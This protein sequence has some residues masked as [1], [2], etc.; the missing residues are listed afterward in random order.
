[1]RILKFPSLTA[2]IIVVFLD[3]STAVASMPTVKISGSYQ[4]TAA[5]FRG[6]VTYEVT[7]FPDDE[8]LFHLPPNWYI[9]NDD[10]N[11]YELQIDGDKHKTIQR[12]DLLTLKRSNHENIYLPQGIHVNS[13]T[14]NKSPT[15]FKIIENLRLSPLKYNKKTLL[16]VSIGRSSIKEAVRIRINFQTR[17]NHLP[18]GFQNL[19]WDFIPRL[20]GFYEGKW[21]RK[22]NIS[23]SFRQRAQVDMLDE[24][25]KKVRTIQSEYESP[26]PYLLL[27]NWNV[28]MDQLKLSYDSYFRDSEADLLNRIKHVVVFLKK[29]Q[30]LRHDLEDLR[31][32]LWDGQLKVSGLTVFLPRQLFR[33]PNE[34]YKQFEISI[35]NGIVAALLNREFLIDSHQNPWMLPAIQSEVLRL[36]FQQRFKGN[37]HIFPWLNWINPEYFS[38]H[39][40]RKWLENKHEKE[41]VAADIS[42]DIAYYAHIYH[43]GHEKGFHLLWMLN[44]GRKDYRERLLGRISHFLRRDAVKPEPLSKQDFFDYFAVTVENRKIAE[45][46]L[47]T[48]GHVDYALGQVDVSEQQNGYQIQMEIENSGTLSPI[49]EIK[50]AFND[51]SSIKKTVKTGAGH[52]QFDFVRQPIEIVLDPSFNILDDDLLNNT[53]QFPVKTRLI[54]DFQSADNWLLTFSPLVGDGNTFDKNIL[55]LNLNY[56]YLNQSQLQFNIWKGS[57]DDLLW[58]GEIVQTGFPALGSR[59]YLEAGYLGAVNSVA[60]GMKQET[61]TSYPELGVD[62]S[63][64]KERLDIL[65]DSIFSKN[66]REWAGLK[67]SFGFPI[68]QRA[69]GAWKIDLQGVTGRSLFEPETEYHQLKVEQTVRFDLSDSNIHLGYNQGISSGRVPLQ[70]RYPIGGTEGMSGFPRTTELLFYENRI[71]EIGAS[72]PGVFTHTNINLIRLMWLHRIVSSVNVHFGQGITENG[73]TEDFTDVEISLDVFGEFIDRFEGKGTVAIAQPLGH[74]KYKDYRIILFSNWIF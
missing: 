1:M 40:N 61:F 52:Y 47:S 67:L 7:D 68:M 16:A 29:N 17:F 62:F 70:K 34:F 19:L 11:E 15:S 69:L 39:S 64:W 23:P 66:E 49:L 4:S 12:S 28:H 63:I 25:G 9:E 6:T 26:I 74:K 14:V 65:E 41:V 37:T 57:S 42:Q 45:K 50:F 8:L 54:W 21:D 2:I 32:I 71:F 43:P 72:L 51:G 27:D 58:V 22:N 38:D 10:R 31:F 48:N 33:Y 3:V 46:W 30:L 13:V 36:Y 24:S 44:D 56:E 35:L 53:L 55:G 18:S 59:L 5:L 20:V 60:I 73:I